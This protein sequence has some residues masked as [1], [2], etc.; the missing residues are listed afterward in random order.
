MKNSEYVLYPSLIFRNGQ[1][2]TSRQCMFCERWLSVRQTNQKNMKTL[3]NRAVTF[4]EEMQRQFNSTDPSVIKQPKSL[5]GTLLPYQLQGV[6]WM[7]RLFENGSHGM[8]A[9]EDRKSV[10]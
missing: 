8:L 7:M 6:S 4:V 1:K 3:V 2:R 9:D 5:K 10:V